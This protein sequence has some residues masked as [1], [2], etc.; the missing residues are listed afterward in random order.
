MQTITKALIINGRANQPEAYS[1]GIDPAQ[2]CDL[3]EAIDF[4]FTRGD[5]FRLA[6]ITLKDKTPVTA[7]T[8]RFY[9][10]DSPQLIHQKMKYLQSYVTTHELDNAIKAFNE[11]K[12]LENY[13]AIVSLE[14]RFKYHP[15]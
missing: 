3:R 9:S 7:R 8:R 10:S 2:I 13:K 1:L 14:S 15:S 4:L 12:S 11:F 6:T 5:S